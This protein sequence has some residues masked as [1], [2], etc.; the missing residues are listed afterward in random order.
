VKHKRLVHQ[1]VYWRI[2]DKTAGIMAACS[3]VKVKKI[4][5]KK[6]VKPSP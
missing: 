5:I 2:A 3:G 1:H 4:Y 6:K